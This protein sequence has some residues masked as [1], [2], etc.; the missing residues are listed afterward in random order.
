M[1]GP[2]VVKVHLAVYS[3]YMCTHVCI[4]PYVRNDK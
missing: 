2:F 4:Y 1:A 3:T